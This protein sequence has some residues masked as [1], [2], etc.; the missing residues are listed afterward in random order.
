M[1]LGL[2]DGVGHGE[3]LMGGSVTG[4]LVGSVAGFSTDGSVC[5]VCV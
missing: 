2:D 5:S 3:L 4:S 1:D